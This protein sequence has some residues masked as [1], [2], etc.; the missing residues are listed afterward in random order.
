WGQA[1]R[2]LQELLKIKEDVFLEVK[3]DGKSKP[4][5]VSVRAEANRLIGSM[6]AEGLAIYEVQYGG[7]ARGKLN[8]A[9]TK[10]DPHLLAE[11]A[12]RYLHTD[13]GAEA[14]NLLGTYHLDRGRYVMAALCF[15][16]LLQHEKA[17]KLTPLTLFK[18]CF[19]FHRAQDLKNAEL[20]W[21]R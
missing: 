11:V 8:E 10:S 13:A 4:Q 19:A 7:E 16:R 17:D 6:P 9:K 14:T 12:E 21:K 20:A 2:H 15:E 3:R 5:W 18:A 1:A